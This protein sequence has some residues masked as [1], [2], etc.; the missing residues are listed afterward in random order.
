MCYTLVDIHN[1]HEH[2]KAVMRSILNVDCSE[3]MSIYV[4]CLQYYSIQA[5]ME[6]KLQGM[7]YTHLYTAAI[8]ASFTFK[9]TLYRNRP[10]M[11]QMW[12][13]PSVCTG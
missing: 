6:I 2:L 5:N 9:W 8:G 3:D 10:T 7:S 1:K 11:W 4:T 13:C 12:S